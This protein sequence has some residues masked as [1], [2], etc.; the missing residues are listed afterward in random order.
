MPIPKSTYQPK[1][2]VSALQ[3]ADICCASLY[4]PSYNLLYTALSWSA[5]LTRLKLQSL[6]L[7]EKC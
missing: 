1:A 7:L 3:T 2:C 6:T 4:E 5:G